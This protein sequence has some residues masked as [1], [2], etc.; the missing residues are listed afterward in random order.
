MALILAIIL[1][2]ILCSR[3]SSDKA[4]VAESNRRIDAKIAAYNERK[5]EWESQVY[6]VD[7]VYEITKSERY[8]PPLKK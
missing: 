2:V 7:V 1:I 6:D 4:S 8:R 3:I 5:K